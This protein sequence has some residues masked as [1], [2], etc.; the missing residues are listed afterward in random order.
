M[1]GASLYRHFLPFWTIDLRDSPLDKGL[2]IG[3][4]TEILGPTLFL[5]ANLL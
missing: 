4:L 2:L 5:N 3:G 1:H